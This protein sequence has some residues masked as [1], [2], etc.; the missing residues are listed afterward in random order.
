MPHH[1]QQLL[2]KDDPILSLALTKLEQAVGHAG[3]DV[4]LIADNRHKAHDILRTLR[5]DPANSTA[6]E[7]YNALKSHVAKANRTE[8]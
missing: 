2:K 5:L 1:L 3:V 8:E 7:V 6:L 4:R